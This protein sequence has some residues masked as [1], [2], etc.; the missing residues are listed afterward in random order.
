MVPAIGTILKRK[1]VD[2]PIGWHYGTVIGYYRGR[3]A[4]FES[5]KEHGEQ[6][7]WLEDFSK[8]ENIYLE[9]VMTDPPEIVLLRARMALNFPQQWKLFSNCEHSC[10]KV[11]QGKPQSYQLQVML[12]AAGIA[13]YFV[14]AS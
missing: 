11:S 9:N 14:L 12:I 7:V 1:L 4:V 2:S 5:S 10:R 8:G 6:V 3:I 13:T